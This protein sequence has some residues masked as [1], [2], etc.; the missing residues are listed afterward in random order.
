MRETHEQVATQKLAVT[1][2]ARLGDGGVNHAPS[3]NTYL[4]DRDVQTF[5]EHDRSP[6]FR[7]S[8]ADTSCQATSVPA[9]TRHAGGFWD[10]RNADA[11]PPRRP[12]AK[13]SAAALDFAH[14][15]PPPLRSTSADAGP[16]SP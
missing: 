5:D 14:R 4:C 12:R 10:A 8:M 3:G 11:T 7:P 6:T 16:F 1:A 13:K 15:R 2:T 9:R